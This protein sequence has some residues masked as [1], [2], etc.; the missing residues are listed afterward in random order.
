MRRP[1][2]W[3]AGRSSSVRR[4]LRPTSGLL[5]AAAAALVLTT[6]VVPT[7][8]PDEPP[9]DREPSAAAP[10]RAL[11][12]ELATGVR[13]RAGESAPR[14][15]AAAVIWHLNRLIDSTEVWLN[16]LALAY[17][18]SRE[19][20]AEYYPELAALRDRVRTHAQALRDDPLWAARPQAQALMAHGTL[21][22]A[23]TAYE[24][25]RQAMGALSSG[26]YTALSDLHR[27]WR[28]ALGDVQRAIMT[29]EL[30]RSFGAGAEVAPAQS[31]GPPPTDAAPVRPPD[32]L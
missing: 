23:L 8:T 22:E 6:C 30:E 20:N 29:G 15:A 17:P 10:A 7:W 12:A 21:V 14:L 13:A 26:R 5:G 18:T 24:I 3:L 25:D 9:Q 27:D 4:A 32:E 1:G 2:R 28:R 31:P 11:A 16:T 19:A